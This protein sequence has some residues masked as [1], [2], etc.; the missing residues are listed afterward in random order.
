ML[1]PALAGCEAGYNA[2]TLTYHPANFGVYTTQNGISIDNAFVLGSTTGSVVPPGGRAVSSSRSTRR[3]ATGW[4]RSA[5]R[6]PR[7][8]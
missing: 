1:V 5:R 2:P 6:A 8:R 7:P 4:S 3:T